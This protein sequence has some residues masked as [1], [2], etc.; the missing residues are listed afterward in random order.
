MDHWCCQCERDAE[1]SDMQPELG[2]Q[3]LA[4]TF[5]YEVTDPK[6][7]KEWIWKGGKPVCTAFIELGKPLPYRCDQTLDLFEVK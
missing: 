3:I 4:A 5:A 2:C 6:Y 1:F 7:P